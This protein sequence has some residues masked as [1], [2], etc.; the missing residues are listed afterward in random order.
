MKTEQEIAAR[1]ESYSYGIFNQVTGRNKFQEVK[2]AYIKGATDQQAIADA[3]YND[4]LKKAQNLLEKVN[5]LMVEKNAF[6]KTHAPLIEVVR[7]LQSFRFES[8][9]NKSHSGDFAETLFYRSIEQV[10]AILTAK[11]LTPQ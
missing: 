11:P 8:I 5:E 2:S 7:I 3:E 6:L 4:L 9:R 10:G 1:A